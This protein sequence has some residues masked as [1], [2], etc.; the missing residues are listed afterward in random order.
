MVHAL[1][2]A[3]SEDINQLDWMTPATKKQALG[4]AARHRQQD[5]LSR[6]VARLLESGDQA[7]RCDRQSFRANTFE[8]QRQTEQ[9]RQAGGQARNG[10]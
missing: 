8:F 6:E 3:L 1:E 7:G 4:E 10:T 2:K 9:D 5:R